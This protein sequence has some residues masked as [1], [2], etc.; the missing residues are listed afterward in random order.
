M[1]D[2]DVAQNIPG[3]VKT[4]GGQA[5]L[6]AAIDEAWRARLSFTRSSTENAAGKQ[7]Q[8]VPESQLQASLN[9]DPSVR[10]FGASVSLTHTGDIYA[11]NFSGDVPYGDTT[12]VDFSA[13]YF[14]DAGRHHRIGVRLENAF[15]EEYGRPATGRTDIR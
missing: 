5:V 11:T 8:R 13:R 9:Y 10:P 12:V 14:L 7:L 4:R 6:T 3:E 15:D 2:L 1:Q